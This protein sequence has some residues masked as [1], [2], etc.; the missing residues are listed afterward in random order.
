MHVVIGAEQDQEFIGELLKESIRRNSVSTQLSFHYGHELE[1]LLPTDLRLKVNSAGDVGGTA[2]SLQR[3]YGFVL[4]DQPSI[5][6]DSDMLVAGNFDDLVEETQS[7]TEKYCLYVTAECPEYGCQT[8]VCYWPSN[9]YGRHERKVL[10]ETVIDSFFVS[11]SI[12]SAIAQHLEIRESLNGSWNVRT[13]DRIKRRDFELA[14]FTDMGDQPWLRKRSKY[15][16]TWHLLARELV[17]NSAELESLR[18]EAIRKKNVGPWVTND[19]LFRWR[20]DDLFF[21]P[22][23]TGRNSGFPSL[24][25][26]ARFFRNLRDET[27]ASW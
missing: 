9:L 4:F 16:S 3:L 26:L 27:A 10:A 24:V 19:R 1:A 22:K 14:H 12:D 8:S 18:N 15:G 17:N 11:R 5:Y 2:F 6:L 13:A 21:V 20:F 25:K 23:Y 7:N